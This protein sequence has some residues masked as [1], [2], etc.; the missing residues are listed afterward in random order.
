MGNLKNAK[1]IVL[2]GFTENSNLGHAWNSDGYWRERLKNIVVCETIVGEETHVR[3]AGEGADYFYM[4]WG[5]GGAHNGWFRTFDIHNNLYSGP[6]Y[7]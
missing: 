5:H 1:P 7:G 2:S 3:D 6:P 4:N